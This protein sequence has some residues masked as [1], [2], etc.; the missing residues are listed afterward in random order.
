MKR[1]WDRGEVGYMGTSEN[2]DSHLASRSVLNDVADEA[3]T[4]SNLNASFLPM[5]RRFVSVTAKKQWKISRI[6]FF[7]VIKA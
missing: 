1:E 7:G 2:R 6:Y 3:L 4:I 5:R